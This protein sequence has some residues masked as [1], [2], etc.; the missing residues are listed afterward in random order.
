MTAQERERLEWIAWS[1]FFAGGAVALL[2][3][4]L[5]TVDLMQ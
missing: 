1:V 3:L 4:I 2:F 5:S